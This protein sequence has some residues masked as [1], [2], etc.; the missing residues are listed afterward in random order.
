MAQILII[1][2]F[3]GGSHKQLLDTLI[4]NLYSICTL[5]KLMG[6][7][8]GECVEPGEVQLCTLPVILHY[9]FA[10]DLKD[11]FCRIKN[12]TG[13]PEQVPCISQKLFHITTASSIQVY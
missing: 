9:F 11:D 12:G 2:S 10:K 4:G 3:Y 7:N 6:D 8:I 13:E 1:E 5:L